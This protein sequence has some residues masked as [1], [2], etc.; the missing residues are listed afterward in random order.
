MDIRRDSPRFGK[1]VGVYLSEANKQ[2]LWVP[3]GFAHGF[4]VTSE[5]AELQYKCT[6]YYAPEHERCIRWDDPG[7]GVEWP[8]VNSDV[9]LSKKDS[10]ADML[11]QAE[12]HPE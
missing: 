1:W 5:E 9:Q 8:L 7:I 12:V 6:D 3:P 10:E 4:Y 11:I 2:L